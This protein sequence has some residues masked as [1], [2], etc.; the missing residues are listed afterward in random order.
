MSSA[1]TGTQPLTVC[2]PGAWRLAE[3]FAIRQL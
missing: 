1:I 3:S 2:W